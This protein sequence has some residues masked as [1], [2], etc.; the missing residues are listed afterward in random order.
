MNW[1]E[2]AAYV[3]F[4][5]SKWMLINT[6]SHEALVLWTAVCGAQRHKRA[7]YERDEPGWGAGW[8]ATYFRAF[9]SIVWRHYFWNANISVYTR[10]SHWIAQGAPGR[11]GE[12]IL[13]QGGRRHLNACAPLVQT[14]KC[15]SYTCSQEV[16]SNI[17]K[18]FLQAHFPWMNLQS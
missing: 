1:G 12:G 18:Q 8:A 11:N 17:A 4:V 13:Q 5:H 9:L 15:L 16:I 7:N 2:C 14:D 6:S 10:V 3:L